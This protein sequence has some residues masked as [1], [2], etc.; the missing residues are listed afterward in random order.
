[1]KVL[2]GDDAL[3]GFRPRPAFVR[4][5]LVIADVSLFGRFSD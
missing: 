5:E 1:M 2:A 3:K 4:S